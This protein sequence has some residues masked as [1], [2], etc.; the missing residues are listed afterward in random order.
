MG[1]QCMYVRLHNGVVLEGISAIHRV[2]VA[3]LA[4][5]GVFRQSKVDVI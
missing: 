3:V 2:I 4:F 1:V 5:I